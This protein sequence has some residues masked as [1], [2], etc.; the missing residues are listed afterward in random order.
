MLNTYFKFTLLLVL[1]TFTLFAQNPVLNEHAV[2]FEN[3]TTISLVGENGLVMRSS[4]NGVTWVEQSTNISN[5]L[6][7]AAFNNGVSLAAGENGVILRSTDNGI[8][9]DIIL[10][11]ATVNLNDIEIKSNNAVVCGDSGKIY[12]S[13]N[14]GL[15]WDEAITNTNQNLKSVY[16]LNT[17]TGYVTGDNGT[18]LKTN[19]GGG[20]WR[21]ENLNFTSKNFNSVYAVN[22]NFIAIVGDEGTAFL[23]NDGGISWFGPNMLMTEDNFNDIVFFN[24]NEGIIAGD[25]GL[26]L[27]TVDGGITWQ[28]ASINISGATN[29]LN[30]VS[31]YD[32]NKGVAVGGNGLEIYTTDGG[33]T[34]SDISP[35]FN[36]VFGSKAQNLILKQNYPNPFNPSTNISYELPYDANVTLKVYDAAGR[37]V[38]NLVSSYQTTGNHTVRFDASGLSSG[39]YFY[40]LFV[41]KGTSSITKVNKMILTK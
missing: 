41:Q 4:D 6:F 5:A 22:E 7:G 21:N 36:A 1:V 18:L 27:K 30:A 31:F 9:W 24:E 10:P 12:Y 33:E 37:E 28:N 39:V 15:T 16:F 3:S 29:D 11:G 34:W 20:T 23:S 2:K 35:S 17:L 26:I 38:A 25:N 32:I 40:K 19:D 13:V 8:T 14:A